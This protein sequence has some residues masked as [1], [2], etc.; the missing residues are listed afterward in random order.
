MFGLLW[1]ASLAPLNWCRLQLFGFVGCAKLC[2]FQS[3]GTVGQD[4]SYW[5]PIQQVDLPEFAL[6]DGLIDCDKFDWLVAWVL[7]A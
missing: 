5:G 7:R 6:S 1:H 3:D 4:A 2:L